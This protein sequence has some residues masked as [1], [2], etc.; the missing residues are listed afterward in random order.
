MILNKIAEVSRQ[1]V[2]KKKQVLPLNELIIKSNNS[3]NEGKDAKEDFAF[4]K[5]LKRDEFS[6]ICEV[7]K[8]SPSKGIINKEFP[9]LDIALKYEK[10]GAT[11]ISVLTEPK[12]FQGSDRYL[13]EISKHV[14]IPVLRKDFIID[15]YQIYEA[16]MIGADAVLL[17]CSLLSDEILKDFIKL[18][19]KLGMSSLVEAHSKDEIEKA[20]K[21]EARVIGV[22]NRNLKTFDVDINNCIELRSEVPD[23]IIFVAESGITSSEDIRM[24]KKNNINVALVGEALMRSNDIEEKIREWR[25][26]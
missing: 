12:F 7:K 8:A 17:I 26:L 3:K 13:S 20:I 22:N 18:S 5:A 1:R 9:Y 14:S 24:L 16:K 6:L 15:E 4:E 21:A 10:A 25:S 2:M 19:N 11:A 23:D